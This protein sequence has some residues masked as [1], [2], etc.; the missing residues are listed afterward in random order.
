MNQDNETSLGVPTRAPGK[1]LIEWIRGPI[2]DAI[3]ARQETKRQKC[4]RG[5]HWRSSVNRL[6]LSSHHRTRPPNANT[7]NNTSGLLALPQELRDLISDY[8]LMVDILC[9]RQVCRRLRYESQGSISPADLFSRQLHTFRQRLDKDGFEMLIALEVRGQLKSKLRACGFCLTLHDKQRFSLDQLRRHPRERQ[10]SASAQKHLICG[11]LYAYP[12]DMRRALQH[13]LGTGRDA[14]PMHHFM[15]V[16]QPRTNMRPSTNVLA[17]LIESDHTLS[18]RRSSMLVDP[19]GLVL[20]HHFHLQSKSMFMPAI[21]NFAAAVSHPLKGSYAICPHLN[22]QTASS[23]LLITNMAADKYVG[24]CEEP[25]CN[26]RYG[27][28]DCPSEVPGW[29]DLC[30]RIKRPFGWMEIMDEAW[31]TRY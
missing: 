22:I 3:R 24:M 7:T 6:L 16:E 29:R 9:M 15:P 31:M 4:S 28:F 20:E 18:M 11:H 12:A 30:F 26:T 21:W 2:N 14:F 23:R 5:P 19:T 17:T 27:W 1:R 25:G 8:L 13:I 10:C